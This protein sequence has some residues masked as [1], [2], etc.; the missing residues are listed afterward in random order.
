MEWSKCGECG[1]QSK[2]RIRSG[3]VAQGQLKLKIQIFAVQ[4]KFVFLSISC[5]KFQT[6]IPSK[7]YQLKGAMNIHLKLENKK[8]K[9]FCLIAITLVTSDNINVHQNKTSNLGS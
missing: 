6:L 1:V 8:P 3:C 5:Q 7:R 2:K 9:N 4:S